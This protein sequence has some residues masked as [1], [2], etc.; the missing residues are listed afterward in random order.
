MVEFLLRT[1]MQPL[2]FVF[3]FTYVFPKI[4]LGVGG[5]RP[6]EGNF[7][8]LLADLRP[9]WPR[10]ARELTDE[11]AIGLRL[12]QSMYNL[13]TAAAADGKVAVTV[14]RP[15]RELGLGAEWLSVPE[16]IW[17][18]PAANEIAFFFAGLSV[19]AR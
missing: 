1:V 8:T 13:D 5:A 7:S 14:H 19:Y 18:L 17:Y 2:L 15:A 4:G 12:A 10:R 9:H 11:V 3:V 16:H 6:A